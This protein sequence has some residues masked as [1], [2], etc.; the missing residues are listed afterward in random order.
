MAICVSRVV[1]APAPRVWELL[2]PGFARVGDWSTSC[3]ESTPHAVPEPHPGAPVPG[4]HCAATIAGINGVVER[5]VDYVPEQHLSYEVVSG[6][7][8]F[9]TSAR[10]DWTVAPAATGTTLVTVAGDLV[11]APL[12]R[13]A[14]PL[15]EW[16]VR[17]LSA[18]AVT[19]LEHVLVQGS[20]TRR[21]ERQAFRRGRARRR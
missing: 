16:Y 21:K 12:A 14:A 13:F 2:G 3:P 20:P 8:P 5:V 7:P 1:A 15:F 18:R 4:R 6:L 17:R 19:E 9:L 10:S 11:F